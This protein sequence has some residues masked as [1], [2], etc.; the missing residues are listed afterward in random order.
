MG[1]SFVVPL[2]DPRD[3]GIVSAPIPPGMEAEGEAGWNLTLAER[4]SLPGWYAIAVPAD[5]AEAVDG[6][7]D[8]FATLRSY[9]PIYRFDADGPITGIKLEG[10]QLHNGA[11][12]SLSGLANLKSISLYGSSFE[13]D[14]LRYLSELEKL[15]DLGL[16]RTNVSDEGLGDVGQI[17]N[18]RQVWLSDATD[19]TS[20]A[21][22]ALRRANPQLK[23]FP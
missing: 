19:L 1:L 5:E 21:I 3:A 12:R 23:V 20:T 17:P 8:A 11:F 16:G 14:A 7:R 4:G 22:L 10:R 6:D 2:I 18:L 9:D 15:E 13:G